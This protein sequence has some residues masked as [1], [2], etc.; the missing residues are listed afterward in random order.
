M[1]SN[2]KS[3]EKLSPERIQKILNNAKTS[4]AIEGFEVTE[5]EMELGKE[6]LEGSISEQEVLKRI[7]G[8]L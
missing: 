3:S 4:M 5:K 8:G 1:K 2:K 7:K 6:Y